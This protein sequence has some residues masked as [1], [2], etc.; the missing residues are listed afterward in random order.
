VHERVVERR[1]DVRDTEH[2][3][4]LL[5]LGAIGG[6]LSVSFLLRG[7]SGLSG[8]NLLTGSNFLLRRLEA[9]TWQQQ[10]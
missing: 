10:R 8:L 2:M 5:D 3:L 4:S 6:A 1:I 9:S 7:G